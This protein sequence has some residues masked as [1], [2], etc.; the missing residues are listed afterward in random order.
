MSRYRF[1]KTRLTGPEHAALCARADEAGVTVSVFLHDIV[2]GDQQ[3]ADVVGILSRIEASILSKPQDDVANSEPLLVEV[4]LLVR[5][6]VAGRNAQLLG[7]VSQRVT[8]LYP[9]RKVA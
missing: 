7:Q 6:L 4:L 2:T 5:E 8:A 1:A 3:Q 9:A